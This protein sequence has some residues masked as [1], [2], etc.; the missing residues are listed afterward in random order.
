MPK[1]PKRVTV[2]YMRFGCTPCGLPAFTQQDWPRGHRWVTMGDEQDVSGC[3]ACELAAKRVLEVRAQ[4]QRGL[5][6]NK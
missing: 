3:P 2:H 4:R 5:V 1:P 6:D